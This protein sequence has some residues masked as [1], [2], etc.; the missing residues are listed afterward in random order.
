MFKI[1]IWGGI[2]LDVHLEI[3]FTAPLKCRRKTKFLTVYP[4]IYLPK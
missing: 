1:F 4:M 3:S 2:S